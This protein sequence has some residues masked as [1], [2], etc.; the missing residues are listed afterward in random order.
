MDIYQN[1][2]FDLS[3]QK[4]KVDEEPADP[5]LYKQPIYSR[6]GG[7]RIILSSKGTELRYSKEMNHAVVGDY[8]NTLARTIPV[9]LGVIS[10]RHFEEFPESINV[11]IFQDSLDGRDVLVYELKEPGR[12]DKLRIYADPAVGYR[13]RLIE[14]FSDGK[15]VR[16]II[17]KDYRFFDGIPLPSFHE[18]TIY[19]SDPNAPIKKTETIQVEV[20]QFNQVIDPKVFKIQ[21]TT[22]SIITDAISGLRFKPCPDKS[23]KLGVEDILERVRAQRRK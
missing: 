12:N 15:L 6:M 14:S 5:N 19:R 16:K 1:Y 22:D 13:Y 11:T 3:V 7:R 20:A 10:Q 18:D 4:Y 21:F 9:Y 17:A 2:T 23:V 8:A